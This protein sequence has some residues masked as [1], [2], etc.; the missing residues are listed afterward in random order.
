M[1]LKQKTV[2]IIFVLCLSSLILFKACSL[3]G[4]GIGSIIDASSVKETKNIDAWKV[5]ELKRGTRVIAVFKDGRE[6]EGKFL[7]V[8]QASFEEYAQRYQ[9]FR[10]NF[11]ENLY[12]PD[13]GDTITLITTRD[14]RYDVTFVAF[15]YEAILIRMTDAEK[16]TL[17]HLR[18]FKSIDN[19]KGNVLAVDTLKSLFSQNKIPLLSFMEIED[20]N[21]KYQIGLEEI[22]YI[23]FTTSKNSGKITGFIIGLTIDCVLIAALIESS[24]EEPPPPPS[25]EG[26]CPFV[27]SY[28]GEDYILDSETFSGSVF[29][30]AQ[31]TDWD[32]LDYL[33]ENQ[34]NYRL[35][36]TNELAEEQY[37]DE[38]KLLVVDHP[39]NTTVAPAFSGDLHVLSHARAPIS[40]LDKAGNSVL[41]LLESKD[42][43]FWISN[44]FTRI[45]GE[46]AEVRDGL[47]L[48]FPRPEKADSVKLILNVQ[49]TFWSIYLE[50]QLYSLYGSALDIW[51][52]VMN[53][54]DRARNRFKELVCREA[55]LQIQL[56]NGREWQESGYIWFVGPHVSKEQV[57]VLDIHDIPGDL[58]KIRV[59]STVGLWMVNCIHADYST[60]PSLIIN[61]LSP[62]Y[63]QDNSGTDIREFLNTIDNKYY[64]LQPFQSTAEL[65]F[66]APPRLEEYQ[67]T[68]ILKSTGYYTALVKTQGMPQWSI[69]SALGSQPGAFG[70]YALYLLQEDIASELSTFYNFEVNDNNLG[71]Y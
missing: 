66:T 43:K 11:P 51:Y 9:K 55:M 46:N 38:L 32:N 58:L 69:L 44:P 29:K 21:G 4:L 33:T 64:I 68:F 47:Y 7:G 59:E 50:A 26:S 45:C 54:S 40:A 13:I 14:V 27:Y 36:I 8:K 41:K 48:E 52:N 35:K 60:D 6:M 19:R 23:S 22:Q 65:E 71:A 20:I 1:K 5:K 42:D 63:A 39:G 12:L 16:S 30:A 62:R 37:I 70:H 2:I 24:K 25:G 28:N 3:I 49:N 57:L 61:E 53:N 31:R 10:N 15:E 56:W 34:G 67:R 17:A 18:L